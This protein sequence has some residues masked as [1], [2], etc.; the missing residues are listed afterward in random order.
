MNRTK[1]NSIMLVFSLLYLITAL[2]LNLLFQSILL[3]YLVLGIAII[4]GLYQLK[5]SNY[6]SRK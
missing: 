1:R 4:L 2:V 3:T 6:E 5:K